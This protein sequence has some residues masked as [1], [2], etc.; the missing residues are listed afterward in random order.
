M[1]VVS[2]EDFLERKEEFLQNMKQGKLFIHPT[3][4]IYG[5][6]C[7]ATNDI[8]VNKVRLV[9]ERSS[10][11]FSILVPSIDWI[12]E[13]CEVDKNAEEWIA[14]LPG[15]YT[16][17][18]KLKNKDAV[19]QSVN[20]GTDTIGVRIPKHWFS[21]IVTELGVPIVTTSANITGHDFMTDF[22]NLEQSIKEKC[23]FGVYEGA[24]KGR[25]STVVKLFEDQV[26]LLHR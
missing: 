10:M 16:L 11:P 18:L 3:D 6:G 22:E 19:P 12:H 13:N 9:K 20:P 5:I 1:E 7:D 15:P 23:T 14:K 21:D 8:A 24:K 2:K 17:V 4:T 26:E 25:P